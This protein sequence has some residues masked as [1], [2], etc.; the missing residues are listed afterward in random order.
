MTASSPASDRSSCHTYCPWYPSTS[1]T[2]WYVSASQL[3]PGN[4]TIPM[5]TR[6]P[7]SASS[8]AS[9]DVVPVLLDQRVREEAFAHVAYAIVQA[10]RTVEL[11]LEVAPGADLPHAGVAQRREPLLDRLARGVQHTRLERHD[12]ANGPHAAAHAQPAPPPDVMTAPP[13]VAP[14]TGGRLPGSARVSPRPHRRAGTAPAAAGPT[15]RGS[16]SR[17]RPACRSSPWSPSPRRMPRPKS[18]TSPG[19]APHR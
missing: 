4:T 9:Y 18:A 10:V 19:S 17:A 12:D 3:L 6:H 5:F 14:R 8:G 1:R 16:S 15:P 11:D 13:A 2:A 7:S